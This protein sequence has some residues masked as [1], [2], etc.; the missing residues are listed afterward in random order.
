MLA[1]PR[2]E[3]IREVREVLFV[4]RIQYLDR[5][6]LDNLVFQSSHAERPLPPVA[7]WYVCPT[8][9]LRVIRSSL[10]S[11]GEILEIFLEV[12]YVVSPCLSVYIRKSLNAGTSEEE[13]KPLVQDQ[14]FTFFGPDSTV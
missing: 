10:Q 2:T 7:F 1:S 11:M 6:S 14:V 3:S 8:H 4:D 12:L 5:R 9:W 13:T